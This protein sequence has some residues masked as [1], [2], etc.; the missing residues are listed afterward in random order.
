MQAS[1]TGTSRSPARRIQR[2]R[3][4]RVADRAAAHPDTAVYSRGKS[5]GSNPYSA[6][7]KWLGVLAGQATLFSALLFY[8]GWTRTQS[9]LIYFGLDNN[10][11]RLGWT[12]YVLRSSDFIVRGA[13]LAVGAGTAIFILIN[14]AWGRLTPVQPKVSPVLYAVSAS[15][16]LLGMAGV[17]DLIIFSERYPVVPL[18]FILAAALMALDAML[19]FKQSRVAGQAFPAVL[20]LLLMVILVSSFWAT[21]TYATIVGRDYA[22]DIESMRVRRPNVVIY[23]EQDLGLAPPVKTT[24]STGRYKFRYSGTRLL[25]Y[26]SGQ[27]ALIPEGW[28]RESSPVYLIRDEPAIR[29]EIG[30]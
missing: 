6:S 25:I 28:K 18:L 7:V 12:D 5:A 24:T 11:I 15:L 19:R 21:S 9:L 13:L 27:Y 4:G 30:S 3:R 29:I 14:L 16:L 20:G 10:I 17:L 22:Q 2:T 23:S 1:E 26:T 8:F